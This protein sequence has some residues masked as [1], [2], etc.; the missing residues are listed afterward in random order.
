MPPLHLREIVE[1]HFYVG[2]HPAL[3][4]SLDAGL[5]YL[6]NELK[7]HTVISFAI[8]LTEEEDKACRERQMLFHYF[9][10]VPMCAPSFDTT[11]FVCQLIDGAYD[12]H[13][14]V[15]LHCMM[16]RG[17]SGCVAAC[18]MIYAG[19]APLQAI[20]FV[21]QK[22]LLRMDSSKQEHYCFDFY[23]WLKAKEKSD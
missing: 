1:G 22:G 15:Y 12:T 4:E 8:E 18:Y 11:Y 20:S 2:A 16:G 7:I 21:T 9:P 19:L 10:L 13:Q 23:E 5:D 14:N 3:G 17:R 6:K